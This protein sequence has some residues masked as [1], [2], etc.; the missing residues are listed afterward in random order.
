MNLTHLVLF[1]FLNGAGQ[2]DN[3]EL[4]AIIEETSKEPFTIYITDQEPFMF[5]E[6]SQA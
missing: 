5:Q 2:Q 4:V 6:T 1:S 3:S